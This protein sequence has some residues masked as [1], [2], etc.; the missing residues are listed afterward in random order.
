MTFTIFVQKVYF[1]KN[2]FELL[3]SEKLNEKE[4]IFGVS[5]SQNLT[6]ILNVFWYFT[7]LQPSQ[8]WYKL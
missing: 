8:M 1:D 3:I 7:G 5:L 2:Y 4:N 6:F